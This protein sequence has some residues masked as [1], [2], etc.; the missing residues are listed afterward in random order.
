MSQ[1]TEQRGGRREGEKDVPGTQT[2]Q[3]KKKETK[4]QKQNAVQSIH[5]DT[6]DSIIGTVEYM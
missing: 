5:D 6:S 2:R 4:N 1:G 3:R